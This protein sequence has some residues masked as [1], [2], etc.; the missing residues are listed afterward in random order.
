MSA[1]TLDVMSLG[2]MLVVFLHLLAMVAAG[3]GIAFGDYALFARPRIDAALLFKAARAVTMTLL[4]LWL[5]GLT[6][7]GLDT[8]FD[9][10]RLTAGPKLP[11]KF[12]VVTLLS[13]NGLAL[14]RL[15]FKRL[16]T[17]QPDARQA[18]SLPA[19]LG[20][21]SIVSWLYAAFLGLAQPWAA[22]LGFVGFMGVYAIALMV[23]IALALWLIRP[24]L[25]HQLASSS[26]RGDLNAGLAA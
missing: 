6:L 17:P 24:R 22:L 20:A 4:A 8:G 23:G 15:A 13:L 7:I 14:H 18:S 12:A 21:I 9:L 26:Q 11:A 10:D 2:R 19:V 16:C 5:S 25:A 1:P 3:A